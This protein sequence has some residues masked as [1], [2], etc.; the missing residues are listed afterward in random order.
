MTPTARRG[1]VGYLEGRYRFSERRACR[2]IGAHRRTMRYRHTVR[3]D[4]SQLRE[5]LRT[6]AA[7]RPQWGYRRLHILLT[8]EMGTINRKRVYRL[9]RLEGLAVRRRTRK[10]AA[11]VPRG[12]PTPIGRPGEAWANALRSSE[13]VLVARTQRCTVP[14]LVCGQS[15]TRIHRMLMIPLI[16]HVAV[17]R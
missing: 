11:R 2:V 6:L 9:Y 10:R 16:T 12:I 1:A 13:I 14:C 8:R 17:R 7:E 4:E 15:A 3:H 5:R